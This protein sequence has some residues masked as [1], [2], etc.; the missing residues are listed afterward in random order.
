MTTID[1]IDT[2]AGT[3]RRAVV[4]KVLR[5]RHH[6][7]QPL[8]GYIEDA[9]AIL[10]ALEADAEL[11]AGLGPDIPTAAAAMDEWC[12]VELLGHRRL[13]AR[14]REVTIAGAGMLRLDEPA[15]TNT[16][17]R[18][19]YV[20]PASIYALHP[21]TEAIV[22]TMCADWA[23][24][25]VN[26]WDLQRAAEIESK[27]LAAAAVTKPDRWP[28]DENDSAYWGPRLDWE[29]DPNLTENDSPDGT[30]PSTT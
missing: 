29:P 26:R 11:M 19:Q 20:N 16:A 15:T 18:T 10:N 12:I 4:A 24:E 17:A 25:P 1:P 22:T 23:T 28:D 5:D 8:R 13:A 21:T 3:R 30:T 2:L 7:A 9:V 27:A 6:A 14:V